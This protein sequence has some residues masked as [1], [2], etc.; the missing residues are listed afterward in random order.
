[1]SIIDELERKTGSH[2]F[3][4]QSILK[5][6]FEGKLV[7]QDPADEPVGMLLRGIQ[8]RK[9]RKDAKKRLRGMGALRE[10]GSDLVADMEI[11]YLLRKEFP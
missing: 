1:M 7:P 11:L 8:A 6:A 10:R 5:R 3:P 4:F 2:H 9:P